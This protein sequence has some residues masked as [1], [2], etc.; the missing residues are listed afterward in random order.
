MLC[1][2][3]NSD[4]ID[5][6]L[7]GIDNVK[8]NVC[9]YHPKLR[10]T[11][12]HA[13]SCAYTCKKYVIEQHERICQVIRA[14]MRKSGKIYQ[15]DREKYSDRQKKNKENGEKCHRGDIIFRRG[16]FD[17]TIDVIVTSS[18]NNQKGNN[19]T[20]AKGVKMREYNNEDIHI[21]LFDTAGNVT[22]ESWKFLE[23]VGVRMDELRLIQSIIFEC[24]Q[25]KLDEII[26]NNKN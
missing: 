15:V 2:R 26:E 25:R 11:L 21:V 14:T 17:E 3:Y 7:G 6:K 12:Q 18:N 8:E 9:Q 22:N 24:T 10:M 13:I 23:S 20:R 4:G 16:E 5:Y 1:L 19:V